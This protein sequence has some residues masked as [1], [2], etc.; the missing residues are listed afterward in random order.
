MAKIIGIDL[1]TTYSAVSLWDEQKKVPII[2]PNLSGFYTTPSIV[3]VN[4]AGE[5]IVGEEARRNLWA[6]PQDTVSEVKREMGNDFKVMMRGKEYNPQ[7]I[8]AFILAYLKKCAEQ[9]LG[10]P[11]H[12]VVITVPAYFKEV[13]ASATKAA[14]EIAGFNVHRLIKEPTAAAIAYGV[15]KGVDGK[16]TYAVYDLGGGTFDVSIIQITADDVTVVGTG[17]DMRLGGLDM[18]EAVMKWA[19]REIKNSEGIDLSGDETVKR[20]LKVEAEGIKKTLVNSESTTLIVPFLTLVNGQPFNAELTITRARFEMLIAPLLQRSLSCLEE[21]MSRAKEENQVEWEDL[22]G[23]LLVGGPTRL[24]KIRSMLKEK[25]LEHCPNKEPVV[26]FDMNPDEV[27]AMGAAIVAAPLAP[28]GKP[29]EEVETMT[30]EQVEAVKEQNKGAQDDQNLPKVDIYDVTSHSLGIAVDGAKF[31]RIIPANSPIPITQVQGPFNNAADFTTELLVEVYQGEE[32]FVAANTRIGEVRIQNL[33]PLPRGQQVVEI[34]FTL[35]VSDT[36]STICKDLRT[37]KEYVGTFKFDGVK[38]MSGD[39]IRKM[40][41]E[42]ARMMQGAAPTPTPPPPPVTTTSTAGGG[43]IPPIT[44]EQI[45]QNSR[46]FWQQA[47]S[48]LPRLDAT[49]QAQLK[50]SMAR[51]AHAVLGGDPNQIQDAE[52]ML[53]DALVEATSS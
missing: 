31:H 21:A 9:Y 45:P 43:E 38:K 46:V 15:T 23:I 47:A 10:E 34:K 30:Q 25:L 32:D 14:G 27:V 16:K 26:K 28:I 11:V 36:L 2:I 35:D 51:F 24:A 33:E 48:T 37:G 12:D 18:D 41:E 4:K 39:E 52:Y 53:Q 3:S 6:A 13:Q 20:R 8:S 49:K 50:S 17:G 29:P 1:G 5:V 44:L 19:L 42:L 7:T 40:R 22:D